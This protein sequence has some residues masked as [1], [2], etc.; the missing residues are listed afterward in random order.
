MCQLN[1]SY[2]VPVVCALALLSYVIPGV[3]SASGNSHKQLSTQL[4]QLLKKLEPGKGKNAFRLPDSHQYR[5]I[6]QD[7]NN[8]ITAAKVRLG[9][10]LFHETAVGTEA[11]ADDRV[12]TYSCATCHHAAAGFKAGIPQGIGDGGSGF[13]N[14]GSKRRLAAG[15][16]PD[17]ADNHPDKPDLQPVTSPAALNA[18]YQPVMLWDGS[19]GNGQ[20]GINRGAAKLNVVGPPG[21]MV[22]AFGLAGL[23]SQV[24][25]GTRVHRLRFDKNSILQTNKTYKRLY[26]KA[27]PNGYTGHIPGG[28]IVT[29]E[30]LG[31][32]KAIAAYERTI[33]ANKAPF[34]RW[35]RGKRSA[36][37]TAQLRGALLFFGE[38]GNCVSCHTGP[39]LSSA[40]D[41]VAD[42]MF[43]SVGFDDFDLNNSRIFG[44]VSDEVK[45]GRGNFTGNASDNFK[46]K[47]PQLYNLKDTKVF[48]H[49]ASFS[50]IGAVIRYKNKA[51]PQKHTRNLAHNFVPLHLNQREIRDLTN[52][53]S[54]AL[55]DP[56]LKRYQPRRLPSGNCFPAGDFQSA[57]DLRC[58]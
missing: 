30:A 50:S 26:K 14:K 54:N 10:L 58:W 22:N 4:N 49:G 52:F 17:A 16:N 44:S 15:M 2:T 36:M 51:V 41:A 57:L 6:P 33:L 25:A 29:P 28:S 32:A 53:V 47:V 42:D 55:Y 13:A 3:S 38:K 18:A 1:R 39:A 8:R 24:L 46:F 45:R 37:T 9:K 43:F 20:E 56:R 5:Q 12:E 40:P 11:T 35:I 21:V 48:G 19:L 27:F 31:A 7:R 23:E 34:Q